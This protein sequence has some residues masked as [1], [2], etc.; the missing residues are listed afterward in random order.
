MGWDK[1]GYYY[2]VHKV[3]GQ[4][5]REYCGAGKLAELT[6][7]LDALERERRQ[8]QRV[9]LCLERDTLNALDETANLLARAAL[10]AAGFQ[11]HKRGEWRKKRERNQS[12]SDCPN[13]MA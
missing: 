13:D 5:I 4:V 10:L 6:A 12:A 11:Q 3:A 2:R 7:Q 8:Q 9:A 1:R